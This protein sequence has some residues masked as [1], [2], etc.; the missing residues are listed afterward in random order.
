MY[1]KKSLLVINVY[2]KQTFFDLCRYEAVVHM[3]FTIVWK[4]AKLPV[5]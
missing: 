1:M 4:P 2:D 5:P 3:F